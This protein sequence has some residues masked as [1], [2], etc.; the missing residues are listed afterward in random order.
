M[1]IL[2]ADDH[3]VIQ[4]GLSYLLKDLFPAVE[5]SKVFD[6]DSMQKS[7]LEQEFDLMIMD[8]NMPGNNSFAAFEKIMESFPALKVIIYSQNREH[9]Y[10]NRF[11][12]LGAKAYV[13]KNQ[14]DDYVKKAIQQVLAGKTWFSADVGHSDHVN[15]PR[16]PFIELSNREIEVAFLLLKGMD[17]QEISN[18]MSISPSTVSTYKLR[19]FEKLN[20]QNQS[21]FYEMAKV[22]QII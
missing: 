14:P 21:Q 6:A 7:L 20:V 11:K 18:K 16:N 2:L 19:I 17:Y 5:I 8:V 1:R 22:Y 13:E 3:P 10:A 15:K 12:D 9:I 4:M